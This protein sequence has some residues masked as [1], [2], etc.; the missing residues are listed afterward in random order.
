MKQSPHTF[1]S[2]APCF[3]ISYLFVPVTP[4]TT[5]G[6]EVQTLQIEAAD[7]TDI[8]PKM[9]KTKL[10]LVLVIPPFNNIHTN[11]P[12]SMETTTSK[13]RCQSPITILSTWYCSW[14]AEDL[15]VVVVKPLF[16]TSLQLV[17]PKALC[18]ASPHS[19]FHLVL[20]KREQLWNLP[21]ST[22]PLLLSTL[23]K[24]M[25]RVL[26]NYFTTKSSLYLIQRLW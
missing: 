15:Q 7:T 10:F 11:K 24:W 22:S 21:V 23:T 1:M 3:H 19:L 25:M 9:I 4:E 12:L 20:T 2:L 14:S 5:P 13:V 18:C 6:L 17:S 8:P 26:K 16:S